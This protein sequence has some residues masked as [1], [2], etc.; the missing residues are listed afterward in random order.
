MLQA[1]IVLGTLRLAQEVLESLK[2]SRHESVRIVR[3]ERAELGQFQ[4]LSVN[5][6][7]LSEWKTIA[8][9]HPV[10]APM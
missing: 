7:R 1:L 8:E 5:S 10:V 2:G 6:R 3:F 4:A 9:G